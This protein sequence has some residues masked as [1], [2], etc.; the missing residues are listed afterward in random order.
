MPA[1]LI[2]TLKWGGIALAIVFVIVLI[3]LQLAPAPQTGDAVSEAPTTLYWILLVI[4]VVTWL[5]I[6]YPKNLLYG[7][8]EHSNPALEPSALKDAMEEIIEARVKI[9]CLKNPPN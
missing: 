4:G 7:K 2:P 5:V 8:E 3:D 9:E 6:S 1:W